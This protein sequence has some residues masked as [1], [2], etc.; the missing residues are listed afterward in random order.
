MI[1]NISIIGGGNLAQCFVDRIIA[2][3]KVTKFQYL[4]L[5]RKK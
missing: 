5:T 1:K 4:T 3:K 2:C